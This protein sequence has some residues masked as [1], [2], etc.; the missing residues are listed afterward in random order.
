MRAVDGHLVRYDEN[1]RV[2]GLTLVNAK[3]LVERDGSIEIPIRVTADD[4]PP[5]FCRARRPLM[6]ILYTC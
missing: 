1:G 5:R 6:C 4:R 2:I 3:W